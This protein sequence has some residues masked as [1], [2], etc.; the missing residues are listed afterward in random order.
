MA[1]L[2]A[3]VYA[4]SPLLRRNAASR[5][6]GLGALASVVPLG[7][8]FPSDR[9]LFWAGLGVLG[10]VAQWVG[11]LFGGP[12]VWAGPGSRAVAFSFAVLRGLASPIAFPLRAA[13]PGLLEDDY[14]RMIATIPRGAGFAQKTVVVLSAPSDVFMA[15]LPI[16]AMGKG[17]PW[18]A[19][20]YTLYAGAEP[21]TVSR[22]GA[23][24]LVVESNQGWLSRF[25][26]SLFRAPPQH[27]GETAQLDAMRATI[28][29]VTPDGRANKVRFDFP[30]DVDDASVVLL[31]WGA[32][33]FEPV[34]PPPIA[35][36]VTV[37]P[38][39][40]FVTDVLRPHVRYR[41]IEGAR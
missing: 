3:F 38:A 21:V 4:A 7:A 28:E 33:G 16:V 17:L 27:P 39:P 29:S 30:R 32:Q 31:F 18:P 14:E 2:G 15:C 26:D 19:H 40:L 36:S 8:T 12:S 34:V 1:L 22:V 37:A 41:P 20:L 25:E 13:T 23:S 5:W 6:F 9:Y 11:L 10:M 24:A 35:A